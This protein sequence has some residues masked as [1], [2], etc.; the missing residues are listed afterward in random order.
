[1]L[2]YQ[3]S[4]N[5]TGLNILGILRKEWCVYTNRSYRN[6]PEENILFNNIFWETNYTIKL[7]FKYLVKIMKPTLLTEL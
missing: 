6:K 7:N 5:F 4:P 3:D 1:M 2:L